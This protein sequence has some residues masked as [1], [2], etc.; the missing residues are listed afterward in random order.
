MKTEWLAAAVVA[1]VVAVAAYFAGLSAGGGGATKTLSTTITQVS[2]VTERVTTTATATQTVTTTVV[3][4]STVTQTVAQPSLKSVIEQMVSNGTF[5]HR[6][7]LCGMDVAEAEHMGV[8]AVVVFSN[9]VVAKT[10]DIGCVFRM[11][12]MPVDKWPFMRRLI[13]ANLTT[14]E[15]VRRVLGNVVQVLVP[16]YGAFMHGNESYVDAEKAYYVILQDRKTPMGDCVFAFASKEVAA[17]HN[18]TVYTFD[19]MLKLYQQ[20]MK[21]KGMPR[22]MWCR[23]EGVMMHHG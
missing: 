17:M 1:V 22:P 6:C 3:Q 9:G 16:D 5:L 4:T 2:T 20:V 10:D 14:A 23:G 19:Q 12:L 21:E 8:S 18:S 7:V 11:R 13:G 15:E